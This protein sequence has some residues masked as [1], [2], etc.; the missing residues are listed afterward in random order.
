M[1]FVEFT[2]NN[3]FQL[4]FIGNT[5]SPDERYLHFATTKHMFQTI[6]IGRSTPPVQFFPLHNGG[7]QPVEFHLDLSPL[8]EL[9]DVSDKSM[10]PVFLYNQY[11][12]ME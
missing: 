5:V 8:D 6:P 9:Q 7:G 11:F 12:L 2:S 3:P 1:I 4:N 10:L